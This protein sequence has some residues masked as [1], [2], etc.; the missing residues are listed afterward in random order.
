MTQTDQRL[1]D[2]E[3]MAHRYAPGSDSFHFRLVPRA[4]RSEVPF[5]TDEY[6]G[7][8]TNVIDVPRAR[9]GALFEGAP[10]GRLNFVFHSA[11]CGSTMLAHAF[12]R[13]GVSSSL[14]EPV[15]LNDLVGFR[16]RG[17]DPKAV[18]ALA[19][20]TLRLLGRTYPGEQAV[21]V[22]PSNI[23]NPLIPA[24]LGLAPDARGVLLH[25]DLDDFLASVAKKGL[26]CRLWGR[27][28][29]RGYLTD[30]FVDL[31]FS[32]EDLFLQSDLQV[33]AVGW[34]AQ[35]QFFARLLGSP[36]TRL[37]ALR[38]GD[39]VMRPEAAIAACSAHF[40]LATDEDALPQTRAIGRDS[41]TGGAFDRARFEA[42]RQKVRAAHGDELEKVAAWARA[43]A[44]TFGIPL[45]LPRQLLSG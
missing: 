9:L 11:F 32:P 15:A 16:R 34:L 14:S 24:L 36:D 2:P 29:L 39:L 17:G 41:K 1:R 27:E 26:W 13:E 33:A 23:V 8:D 7:S 20:A 42:E 25:A 5:L 10:P 30:G 21:V 40:G 22:K 4:R 12:D 37:R 38:A 35:Q 44:A 18:E 45:D 28:L 31:G 3:W 43:V 6:L 19:S